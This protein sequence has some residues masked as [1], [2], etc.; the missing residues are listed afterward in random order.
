MSRVWSS[1]MS[2]LYSGA[3]SPPWGRVVQTQDLPP[4]QPLPTASYVACWCPAPQLLML[5]EAGLKRNCTSHRGRKA[6]VF[7][8]HTSVKNKGTYMNYCGLISKFCKNERYHDIVHGSWTAYEFS[9]PSNML[10]RP[11]ILHCIG[12]DSS[13]YTIPEVAFIR[14]L[15]FTKETV[16]PK[17]NTINYAT[18]IHS[19]QIVLGLRFPKDFT[20]KSAA[21]EKSYLWTSLAFI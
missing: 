14:E 16:K 6:Q 4:T 8:S 20:K 1:D 18:E 9:P 5:E 13:C 12:R 10:S 7:V 3:F 21:R 19:G 15:P 17:Y 11:V 2:I